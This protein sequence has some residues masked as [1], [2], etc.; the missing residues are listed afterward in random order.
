M[1]KVLYG[2]ISS[3]LEL[4]TILG[5]SRK[6]PP[7]PHRWHW[8]SCKKCLVSMTGNPQISPKFCNFFPQDFESVGSGILQ[9]LQ[10]S[11]L[12]ILKFLGTQF[13]V[14]HRG[15]VDIF[16]NSPFH[17]KTSANQRFGIYACAKLIFMSSV[18]F[19]LAKS[20]DDEAMTSR[21]LAEVFYIF[22]LW[23]LAAN[24]RPPT[25]FLT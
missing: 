7:P 18:N 23:Y 17:F 20:I 19:M 12:E 8:K 22:E 4:W 5:Y 9:K 6:Y 24:E 13:G 3:S 10:L 14:I 25:C 2:K 11:F 21:K 16:W 1:A 15:C